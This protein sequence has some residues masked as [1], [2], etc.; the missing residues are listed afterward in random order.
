MGTQF[1]TALSI[2]QVPSAGK[3]LPSQPG[4]ETS[5]MFCVLEEAEFRREEKDSPGRRKSTHTP[6]AASHFWVALTEAGE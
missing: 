2:R 1:S 6:R 3:E 5:G 4:E